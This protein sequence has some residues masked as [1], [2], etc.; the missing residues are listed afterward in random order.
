MS[1]WQVP[2]PTWQ[3]MLPQLAFFFVFED[4]FH[5][6]CWSFPSPTL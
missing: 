1:T 2:F 5:Y 4:M 6:F 3:T